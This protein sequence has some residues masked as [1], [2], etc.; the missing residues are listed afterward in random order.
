M[1]LLTGDLLR[2]DVAVDARV[3]GSEDQALEIVR[4]QPLPSL[5][6]GRAGSKP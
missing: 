1:L 5:C 6:A 2:E 4:L 3:D